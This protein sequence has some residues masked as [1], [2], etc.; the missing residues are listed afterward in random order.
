[1]VIKADHTHANGL[2]LNAEIDLKVF[3]LY[4][5]DLGL[6]NRICGLKHISDQQIRDHSFINNGAI[7]EQFIA[8]QLFFNQTPKYPPA[9]HYWLREGSS[10]N[11]EVDFLLQV[12]SSIVPVEVKSGKSGSLKSL[13]QFSVEK[14][15]SIACR[16]DLN[17]PCQQNMNTKI[18]GHAA[19]LQLISLPLYF[20]NQ[21]ERVIACQLQN[22]VA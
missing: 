1:M 18:N 11:A 6:Y 10:K 2:P 21:A 8:Q 20:C 5:L 16:L 13:Q 15:I 12:D 3:K 9:L 17:L 7:A 14:G 4:S 22:S 19:K